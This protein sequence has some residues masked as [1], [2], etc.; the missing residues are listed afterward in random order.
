M[1]PFEPGYAIAPTRL[2]GAVCDAL[3]AALSPACVPRSRAGARHL[4]R[5]AAVAELAAGSELTAIA[6]AWLGAG[7]VPFRATLFEK[8]SETNWLI[9]WHQDTA[10][11]LTA[12]CASPGWS[13]WSE[14][15]GVAYA[16]APAWALSRVVA[17][18]VHFDPS[19]AD[20]GPLRVLPG[21]HTSGVLTD[22]EILGR[23]SSGNPVECL[24]ERGGILAMRPLL[25][26]ASSK[27][28]STAARRVLHIEYVDSLELGADIRL[29]IV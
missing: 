23:V 4:M 26:H 28:R 17:L 5:N 15:E 24:V 19:E 21:S 1:Q 29:A 9:P 7:A 13:S 3:L 11:P 10:L 14:K 12:R 16:H 25:I 8:S 22:R 18:R 6:R 20:N 2:A 27:A